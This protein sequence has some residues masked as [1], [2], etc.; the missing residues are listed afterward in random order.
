MSGNLVPQNS[1]GM[2]FKMGWENKVSF[3]M[4]PS[5]SAGVSLGFLT[6]EVSSPE[7]KTGK[8]KGHWEGRGTV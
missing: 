6:M 7:W 4:T 5:H 3:T 1:A 8:R 2:K